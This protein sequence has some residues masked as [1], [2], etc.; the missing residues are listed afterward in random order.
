MTVVTGLSGSGKSTLAF[1]IIFAEGQKRFMD[2]MSPYARQFTE[3]ME[4]PDIDRLT[5]LPPTVAIE[6]NRTR[7]GSKSTVGTIT[8]IWQFLRLLYAKLGQPHCPKCRIPVGR[9]SPGEIQALVA[10]ELEKKPECLMIAAPVV[11]NRKGHYADLARWAAKKKYPWLRAD[12][13]LVAPDAFTPLDRYSNHDI[14]VVLAEMRVQGN[15]ISMNGT[16]CDFA[17]LSETVSRALEMGD[18]FL[19][20]LW[21]NGTAKLLGTHLTCPECGESY[22]APERTSYRSRR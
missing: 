9:R 22:A 3:Q 2:V 21:G 19:R 14:D 7:G 15:R 18:G 17:T 13:E 5:G 8:E 1:D 4:T 16:D 20:L 6:Q 11:R 12:G 10:Q